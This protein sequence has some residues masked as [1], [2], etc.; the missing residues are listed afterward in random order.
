MFPTDL[1]GL[2]GTQSHQ[3]PGEWFLTTTRRIIKIAIHSSD[4]ALGT[5]RHLTHPPPSAPHGAKP[6]LPPPP[7]ERSRYRRL[8]RVRD[9]QRARDRSPRK[10]ALARGA[11]GEWHA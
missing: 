5:R 6:T 1:Q 7:H 11:I 8:P 3:F 10:E 4:V 9:A 2:T